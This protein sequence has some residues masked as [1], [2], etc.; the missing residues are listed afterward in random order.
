MKKVFNTIKKGIK[1]Y[2]DNVAK[3]N[4]CPS[5]MIPINKIG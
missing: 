2:I 3:Y 4:L 1:W 5:G